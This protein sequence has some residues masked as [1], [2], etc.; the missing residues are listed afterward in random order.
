MRLSGDDYSTIEELTDLLYGFLPA[1]FNSSTAFPIAA[2]M[3]GVGDL[4]ELGPKQSKRPAI[5]SFLTRVLLS[6]RDRLPALMLCIVQQSKRWRANKGNPLT[7]QEVDRLNQ[8]VERLGFR[9]KRLVDRDFL[10]SL[11]GAMPPE[12]PVPE[13]HQASVALAR[14]QTDFL[15]MSA[16]DP[17]PRGYAFEK[18]LGEL[19]QFYQLAPRGAFRLVGEQIDGSFDFQGHPYLLEAKWQNGQTGLQDLL[20]FLGKV[21][22]KATWTRG[23]FV[24]YCGFSTDGLEAFGRGRRTS[25]IAMDGRDIAEALNRSI[26]FAELLGKKIRLAAESNRAFVPLHEIYP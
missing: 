8:L 12:T 14:L 16:L 22:G 10:D 3:A 15:A 20:A 17:Q 7:R 24:S 25:L 9:V 1:S 26:S 11:P 5:R 6:K 19:F 13:P 23:L 18:W 4:W 21:E 2:N